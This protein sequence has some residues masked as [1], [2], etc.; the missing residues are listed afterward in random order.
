MLPNV[1]D[2]LPEAIKFVWNQKTQKFHKTET[3]FGTDPSVTFYLLQTIAYLMPVFTTETL[4]I[5][6]KSV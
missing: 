4:K 6:V 5:I 3:E 2:E 1:K